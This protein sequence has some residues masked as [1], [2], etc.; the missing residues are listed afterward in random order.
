MMGD[1]ADGLR[2]LFAT[3]AMMLTVAAREADVIDAYAKIKQIA[4]EQ[5]C[6]R[7]RIAITHARSAVEAQALFDNM[8]RVAHE[9][10]GV[11]LEFAGMQATVENGRA[12]GRSASKRQGRLISV[13]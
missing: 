2:R 12:A 13:I 1:Q 4:H 9:Y 5:Q 6:C 11:R 8:C 10:L 7:F 3:P